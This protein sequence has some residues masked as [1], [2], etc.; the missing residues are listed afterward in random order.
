[1][2]EHLV[3]LDKLPGICTVG[4]GKKIHHLMEKMVQAATDHKVYQNEEVTTS[5]LGLN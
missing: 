1:M 4:V 5:V 3:A 2:A